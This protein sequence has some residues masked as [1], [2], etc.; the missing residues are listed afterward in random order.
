MEN[1][2]IITY[3]CPYSIFPT[4]SAIELEPLNRLDK[5]LIKKGNLIKWFVFPVLFEDNLLPQEG[6]MSHRMRPGCGYDKVSFFVGK[7]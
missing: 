2:L 1:R 5:R 7:I 6:F 3:Y 4:L